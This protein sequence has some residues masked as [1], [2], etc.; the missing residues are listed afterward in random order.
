MANGKLITVPI[1]TMN[2]FN[3][4]LPAQG[5][6]APWAVYYMYMTGLLYRVSQANPCAFQFQ[7]PTENILYTFTDFLLSHRY[8][9]VTTSASLDES[10]VRSQFIS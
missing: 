9:T 4:I 8:C 2:A 7:I 3:A 6:A 10:I 5:A 1:V